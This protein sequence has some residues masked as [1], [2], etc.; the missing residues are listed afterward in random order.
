MTYVRETC[1]C[2]GEQTI[3]SPQGKRT[4]TRGLGKRASPEAASLFRSSLGG[5]LPCE[6]PAQW[7]LCHSAQH[8][9]CRGDTMGCPFLLTPVPAH[10]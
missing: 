7:A 4:A 2:C 8:S 6:L 9:P 1:G 3:T 5:V 10:P